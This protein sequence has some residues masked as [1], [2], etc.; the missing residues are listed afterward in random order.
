MGQDVHYNGGIVVD[1]IILLDGKEWEPLS[2][3]SD[4]ECT[5]YSSADNADKGRSNSLV[6][7][8]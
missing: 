8:I 6:S 5:K 3:G 7:G 1:G 2:A 4:A